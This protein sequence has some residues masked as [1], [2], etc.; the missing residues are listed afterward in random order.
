[1]REIASEE[2]EDAVCFWRRHADHLAEKG[3]VSEEAVR[4]VRTCT[5]PDSIGHDQD[6]CEIIRP[7]E[8]GKWDMHYMAQSQGFS[9]EECLLMADLTSSQLADMER[10][11]EMTERGMDPDSPNDVAKFERLKKMTPEQLDAEI[12][13]LEKALS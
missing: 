10:R 3:L 9:P 4:W 5:G 7:G 12:A 6:K 8:N 13:R 1:M 2:R 11:E